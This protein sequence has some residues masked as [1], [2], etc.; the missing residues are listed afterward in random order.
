[1]TPGTARSADRD[2]AASRPHM[3]GYGIAPAGD[4]DGLLPWSWAVHR[5]EGA[6]RYWLA[7]TGPDGSPTSPP[8]G[9]SGSATPSTSAPAAVPA[10]PAT[11][12]TTRGA[13]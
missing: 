5:L 3:P 2:P 1:M 8:S 12:P 4:G 13:R 10:R 7:T 11:W 6:V 9:G